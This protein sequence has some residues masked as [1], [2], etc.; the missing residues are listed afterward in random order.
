MPPHKIDRRRVTLENS[1]NYIPMYSGRP[2][3]D[4]DINQEDITNL[5]IA[6]HTS[7]S[8]DEFLSLI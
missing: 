1:V 2:N 7:K 6:L 3:R 8:F 5:K 4:Q